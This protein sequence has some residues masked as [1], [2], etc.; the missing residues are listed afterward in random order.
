[1]QRLNNKTCVVTGAARGI[2][3]AIA[4]RFHD[5]GAIVIV[6]DIDEAVGAA[7]AAKIGCRFER[8]DVREEGDWSRLAGVIPVADVMVNNAG[9]TG[10]EA[11]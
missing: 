1:M 3:R 11:G 6:T 7:T 4:A 9:V 2:G 10:F 8:L 5:E